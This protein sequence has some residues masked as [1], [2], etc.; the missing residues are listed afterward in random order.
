MKIP[1]L[2]TWTTG[3]TGDTAKHLKQ[4]SNTCAWRGQ[5]YLDERSD[6]GTF[7]GKGRLSVSG[8]SRKSTESQ[9]PGA[10]LLDRELGITGAISPHVLN[11]QVPL[12]TVSLLD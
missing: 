1:L 7:D 4:R 9:D 12:W 5:R 3:D 10:A 6:L 11:I 8:S 2:K